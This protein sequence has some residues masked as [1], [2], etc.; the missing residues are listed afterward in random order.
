MYRWCGVNLA[1]DM[2]LACYSQHCQCNIN[3][4]T[5]VPVCACARLEMKLARKLKKQ[6]KPLS[7]LSLAFANHKLTGAAEIATTAEITVAAVERGKNRL[8]IDSVVLDDD[9][10]QPGISQLNR[11]VTLASTCSG[12]GS[13]SS[14]HTAVVHTAVTTC[15]HQPYQVP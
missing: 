6:L 2:V 9:L 14:S 4:L 15:K 11:P 10:A 12:S 13:N 8:C 3:S 7:A 1:A 5:N